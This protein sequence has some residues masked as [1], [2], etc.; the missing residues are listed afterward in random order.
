MNEGLS[1][2]VIAMRHTKIYDDSKAETVS[3]LLMLMS[4]SLDVFTFEKVRFFS[5]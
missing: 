5:T 1:G 2:E 3:H 4:D